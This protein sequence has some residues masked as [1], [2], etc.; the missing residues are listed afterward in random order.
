MFLEYGILTFHWQIHNGI[1][2]KCLYLDQ[3]MVYIAEVIFHCWQ[4][5]EKH[6]A[7]SYIYFM[8]YV[9]WL[10]KVP[11]H[12]TAW[13]SAGAASGHAAFVKCRGFT[14]VQIAMA[15]EWRDAFVCFMFLQ[16]S[17]ITISLMMISEHH[18]KDEII[19]SY[20]ITNTVIT[21]LYHTWLHVR[22]ILWHW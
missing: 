12:I 9:P 14:W 16:F 8:A 19:P 15:T 13:Y 4:Q 18:M 22:R 2:V 20:L 5:L 21:I 11:K 7:E 3:C 10:T 17:N 6:T 1:S